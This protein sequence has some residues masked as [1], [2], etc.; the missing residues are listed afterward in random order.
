MSSRG[1][2]QL[3][4][5]QEEQEDFYDC[6]EILEGP[7]QRGGGGAEEVGG[8]EKLNISTDKLTDRGNSPQD[9]GEK[10]KEEEKEEDEEE[11]RGGLQEPEQTDRLQ[12]ELR[13]DRLQEE[14][15]IDR[16]LEGAQTD[17]LQG[18]SDSELKAEEV[19]FDDDYLRELEKDLTE[20]E[21]E[22]P[23]RLVTL[24]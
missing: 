2:D 10:L 3:S 20:E 13:T 14:E 15:H 7:G 1:G 4:R 18:D 9:Q 23:S 16:L 21:K 5:E 19:E 8:G 22:V 6:Q 11:H 24:L 12:E 17:R